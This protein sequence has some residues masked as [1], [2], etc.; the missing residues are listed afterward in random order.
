MK[1]VSSFGNRIKQYRENNNLTL[2]EI[3]HMTNV[4]AQTINRY[5]LGQR[6]PKVDAAAI[7]A[8][9]LK[10]NPL[11]LFGYDVE[12]TDVS[13]RL[14]EFTEHEQDVIM[15][16][17]NHPDMQPA[18][19]RILGVESEPPKIPDL[20]Y[21]DCELSSTI[22]KAAQTPVPYTLEDSKDVTP[23]K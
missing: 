17:R 21:D 4:P 5:E 3:E 23:K 9:K 12:D 14:F 13:S 2:A 22:Q 7:I 8:N 16:Y 6:V 18:V 20:M 10:L 15:E 1:I 11:W 19:D